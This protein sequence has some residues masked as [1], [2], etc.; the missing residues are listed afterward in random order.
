MVQNLKGRGHSRSE[1]IP[2]RCALNYY[3]YES[4]V[5]DSIYNRGVLVICM[6]MC[7]SLGCLHAKWDLI[8]RFKVPHGTVKIFFWKPNW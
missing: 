7:A 3:E 1:I 6:A 5:T 8:D 2:A 4:N